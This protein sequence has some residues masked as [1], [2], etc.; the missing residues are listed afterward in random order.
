MEFVELEMG[1]LTLKREKKENLNINLLTTPPNAYIH[2][3]Y[4]LLSNT[5]ILQNIQR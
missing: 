1:K 3:I 5:N 2:Q 4:V